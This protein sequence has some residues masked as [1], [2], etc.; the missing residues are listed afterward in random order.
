MCGL[1]LYLP[2]TSCWAP[3]CRSLGMILCHPPYAAHQDVV[4]LPVVTPL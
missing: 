1:L 4:V 2:S 3:L